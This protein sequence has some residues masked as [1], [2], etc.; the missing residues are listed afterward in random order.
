LKFTVVTR[1]HNVRLE[2]GQKQ[3]FKYFGKSVA[4][5]KFL[6][7]LMTRHSLDFDVLNVHVHC[8]V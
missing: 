2:S 6:V 3:L 1:F 5:A 4:I 8:P 7:A